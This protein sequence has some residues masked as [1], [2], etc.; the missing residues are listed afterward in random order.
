[1]FGVKRPMKILSIQGHFGNINGQKIDFSDKLCCRVLP[2]GW[3]KTTLCAFIRV[4][5]YGLNT[6]R[7]DTA[8]SLSDKTKYYPQDGKPMSGRM[9]VEFAG[10][11]ITIIRGSSRNGLMQDFEAFYE[12]TGEPFTQITA[13][14]CGE[15]LLGMSE[16][17]FLSSAMV[18]GMDMTRSS[19]ELNELLISL[20][21]TGDNSTRCS[22]ALKTLTR[23]RLDLNSGNGHGEQPRLE[24][25]YKT[26]EQHLDDIAALEA[27]MSKQ[28]EKAAALTEK[29]EKL[30][31]EYEKVYR[32]YAGKVAEEEGSLAVLKKDVEKRIKHLKADLPDEILLR[33]AEDALYGYEGAVEL[34][35]EKRKNMPYVDSK[36]QD[37]VKEVDKRRTKEE[38]K[39]NYIVRPKIR[40]SALILALILA[41]VAAGS[42]FSNI[43]WGKWTPYMP[44]IL[45]GMAFIALLTSFIGSVPRLD[46]PDEDYD[47]SKQQL[48][49]ER[50][51]TVGAQ[52]MATSVL[53]EQYDAVV[54]AASKIWPNVKTVEQAGEWI[55]GARHDLQLLRQEQSKLQDILV[56]MKKMESSRNIDVDAQKLVDDARNKAVEARHAAEY[57][58]QELSRMQG[59]LQTLGNALE[60]R[61][62]RDS[63]KVAMDN[64]EQKM[65]ALKL[66][67]QIIEEQNAVLSARISPKITELAEQYMA[68]LT[69]DSYKEVKLDSSLRARCAGDD[70]TLLDALRLSSG[71]RDQ[72][73]FALRLAVCQVLTGN[74]SV[75]IIL[76]DPFVT[77]DNK[78]SEKGLRL[79]QSFSNERQVI[80]L[81]NRPAG[82]LAINAPKASVKNL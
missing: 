41:L 55:R 1:M 53:Q 80:L 68:Y 61:S 4:M 16:D 40:W 63:I 65:N 78:R 15:V 9:T 72:L 34:E 31:L 2:N 18:D 17:A 20:A 13:K 67:E 75:P 59:R 70:G 35:R 7:R 57:A 32:N 81:T 71:T 28:R 25:D 11:P 33:E 82:R 58:H 77:W 66:A 62:T 73:Y 39:R 44:Y 48:N 50:K 46:D 23:W 54:R 60:W 8:N 47:E 76:D 3:G 51:K 27:Q 36:F 21:Q 29:A 30:H 26:A 49:M 12:D 56:E 43:N 19:S 42:S 79:L 74:E 10:R 45:S 37:A 64:A 52:H 5:L 14:N 38:V 6:S 24:K 69:S 22:S